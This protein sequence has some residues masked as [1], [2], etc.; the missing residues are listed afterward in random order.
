[1]L[2]LEAK[3]ERLRKMQQDKKQFWILKT[4]IIFGMTPP[5]LKALA[6]KF[7]PGVS[8]RCEQESQAVAQTTTRTFW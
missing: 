1:M 6:D 7:E 5:G 8:R 2:D 3:Q 4:K